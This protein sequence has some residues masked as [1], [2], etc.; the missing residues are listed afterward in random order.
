[1]ASPFWT[2]ATRW[3]VRPALQGKLQPQ[4]SNSAEVRRLTCSFAP[5]RSRSPCQTG[6]ILGR[7]SAS[8][9]DAGPS[10]EDRGR[11]GLFVAE[12]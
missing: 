8:G 7:P 1:M 10:S 2:R 6:V 9:R 3:A 11:R 4:G 5:Q 12:R